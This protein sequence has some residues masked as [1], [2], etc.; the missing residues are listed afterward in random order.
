MFPSLKVPK[1]TV[2]S[3]LL[4]SSGA[5]YPLIIRPAHPRSYSALLF[6][7]LFIQTSGTIVP[8]QSK[9][10]LIDLRKLLATSCALILLPSLTSTP[11]ERC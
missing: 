6:L 4:V 9:N 5:A 1:I 10:P 2:S 8:L 3:F 11:P 7:M